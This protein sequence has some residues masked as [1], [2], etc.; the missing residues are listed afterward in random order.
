MHME[1]TTDYLNDAMHRTPCTTWGQ[2]RPQ[3]CSR[4]TFCGSSEDSVRRRALTFAQFTWSCSAL[5][6]SRALRWSCRKGSEAQPALQLL[7]LCLYKLILFVGRKGEESMPRPQRSALSWT[8]F[9]PP[10]LAQLALQVCSVWPRRHK[11][12]LGPPHPAGT[13]RLMFMIAAGGWAWQKCTC[14]FLERVSSAH[15]HM[16]QGQCVTETLGN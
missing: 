15:R 11:L 13:T 16:F 1:Q 5:S 4:S 12:I 3:A 8:W 10:H 14:P 7:L 6:L 9:S 2:L